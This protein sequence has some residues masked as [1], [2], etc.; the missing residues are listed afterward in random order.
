M[1]THS[2]IL[3]WKIPWTQEPGRL[4]SPW[5]GHRESDITEHPHMRCDIIVGMISHSAYRFQNLGNGILRVEWVM[6]FQPTA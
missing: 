1:A 3:A 5:G 6:C 2:S 4:R